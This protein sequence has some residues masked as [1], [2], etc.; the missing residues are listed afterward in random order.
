MR[1]VLAN[2]N[3]KGSLQKT[4]WR[5]STSS[6]KVRWLDDSRSTKSSRRKVNLETTT[7]TQSWS[8]ILPLNVF[9]HI[10]VK[11]KLF[12]RRKGVYGSFSSCRRKSRKSLILTIHWNLQILWRRIME[13]LYDNTPSIWDEW[14]CRKSGTPLQMGIFFVKGDSENNRK[15]RWFLFWAIVECHPIYTNRSFSDSWKGFTKFAFLKEDFPKGYL[16]FWRPTYKNASN[17]LTWKFV[18][19]CVSIPTFGELKFHDAKH[20]YSGQVHKHVRKRR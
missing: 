7:D 19:W 10:R 5:S 12:R 9:N 11:P 16:W 20:H 2:E 4:H 15:T 8:K 6:R 14:Y 1:S 18:A 17:Y 13:S 3:N